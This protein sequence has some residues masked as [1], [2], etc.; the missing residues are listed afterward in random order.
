[1]KTPAPFRKRFRPGPQEVSAIY[2]RVNE[3]L[4]FCQARYY[5]ISPLAFAV[6]RSVCQAS[7]ALQKKLRK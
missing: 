2:L 7:E 5:G 4:Q 6:W 1:M 3:V